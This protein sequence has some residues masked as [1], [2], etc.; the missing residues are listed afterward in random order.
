MLEIEQVTTEYLPL[1]QASSAIYFMLER[2]REVNHFYQFSLH[3]FLDIFESALLSNP[4]LSSVTEREARKNIIL[5]DLFSFTFQR[6][7]RSL[8]HEDYPVLALNLLR[9]MLHI[10]GDTASADEVDELLEVDGVQADSAT[11]TELAAVLPRVIAVRLCS[12]RHMPDFPTICKHI[13]EHPDLWRR[14]LASEYPERDV[15]LLG[16]DLQGK[17]IVKRVVELN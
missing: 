2:L 12:L 15:P 17:R 16:L 11:A 6:T 3:Y 5:R 10:A 14:C 4:N 8:L 1:A 9:I 13:L 7:A